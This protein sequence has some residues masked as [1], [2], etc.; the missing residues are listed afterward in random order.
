MLFLVLA[1]VSLRELL[2]VSIL[3]LIEDH[4]CLQIA[5]EVS[6]NSVSQF[7]RET[8]SIVINLLIR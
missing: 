1:V 4:C 7:K 3:T 5:I 2:N 6:V 8:F